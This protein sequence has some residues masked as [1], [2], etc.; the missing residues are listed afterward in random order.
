ML[1]EQTW[2]EGDPLPWSSKVSIFFEMAVVQIAEELFMP[3]LGGCWLMGCMAF[4]S[5]ETFSPSVKNAAGSGATGLIQFMSPTARGMGT[6]VEALAKLTAEEQLKYVYEYFF[7][8]RNRLKTLSDVYMAILLPKAIGKP[9]SY[10]LFTV[11]NSPIAYKQN[12]GLDRNKDE[13]VTKSEATSLVQAKL[14]K[15][16]NYVRSA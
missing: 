2:T 12:I 13:I 6:T 16:W 4:E 14:D 8:Y 10:G 9:E 11:A 7:P 5:G 1:S 3:R 15:G